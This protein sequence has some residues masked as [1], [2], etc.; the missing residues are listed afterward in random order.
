MFTVLIILLGLSVRSDYSIINATIIDMVKGRVENTMLGILT[1]SRSL[2]GSI[3]PLIAGFLYQYSGMR[4]T[5]I[6]VGGLF[7]LA[8]LVFAIVRLDRSW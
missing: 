1:F 5:L 4:A 3:A 6:F 8:S 7:F 2:L